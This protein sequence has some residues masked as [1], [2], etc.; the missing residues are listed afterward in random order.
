MLQQLQAEQEEGLLSLGSSSACKN[1]ADLL[2]IHRKSIQRARYEQGCFSNWWAEQI[3][4]KFLVSWRYRTAPP[5][6][7]PWQQGLLQEVAAVQETQKSL[8]DAFVKPTLCKKAPA[9]LHATEDAECA[10]LKPVS[11]CWWR[12]LLSAL[13]AKPRSL[14]FLAYGG[15]EISLLWWIR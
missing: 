2:A 8:E 4:P 13:C 11:F 5:E 3:N 10:A 7:H 14:A 12:L 6:Q 15:F 1:R 9:A